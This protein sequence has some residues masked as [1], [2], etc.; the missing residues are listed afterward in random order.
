MKKVVLTTS[1]LAIAAA[2]QAQSSV[3]LYGRIDNGIQYENGLPGGHKVSA[4]SGDWGCS[5]FGM[6]GTE[7]LGGGTAAIFQLEGQLNTMNGTSSGALFGRHAIVG[8][9][10]ANYGTFK[11]GNLG[12]GEIQQ[13]SWALD[14]QLMQ[15]YAISTLTHG[16]N[17]PSAEN[18]FEYTTPNLA[19][20]TL[21]GQ[22]DLSNSTSWNAGATSTSQGRGDGIEAIYDIGALEL[23]S[24]Y[25]ELRSAEGNFNDLYAASRS[26]MAGGTY[27]LGPVK[28]WAGY[29]H[30]NAPQAN[31]STVNGGAFAAA[32]A[33]GLMP[34]QAPTSADHEWL[35]AAWQATPAATLTGAVYHTNVNNGNGN[36]TMY[37]LAATYNL[38]KRTFLYTEA[39]YLHNSATSN[40]DLGNDSWGPNTNSAV[41]SVGSS[42]NPGYGHSQTG[43]FTGIMTA[44]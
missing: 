40:I 26:I 28:I 39:A 37:T 42:T 9:Q 7:D 29:Q 21:K 12:A 2:A 31:D 8:F 24:I 30:L 15:R 14:P 36:A 27:T 19:G 17:W 25:D 5:W 43:V 23:R 34:V 3:T 44:F 32:S 16:R 20:F 4:E 33:A 1:L 38:S 22:Y 18:G 13:D 6:Q 10:N 11:L 41:G 35:G